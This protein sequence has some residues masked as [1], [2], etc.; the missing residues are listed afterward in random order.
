MRARV[1]GGW[2]SPFYPEE[3]NFNYTEANAWQYNFYVP[4]DVYGLM[5]LHG[6]KKEFSLLLDSLFTVSSETSGREQADISG[7]IGQYAHGNEPS[8]HMAY[9][10]CYAEQPE[11]TQVLVRR[12]LEELYTDQPDGLSGNEDCGQMSAWYVFS[13]LGFYPVNPAS[14]TYVIGSPLVDE[15]L[16]DLESGQSLKIIVHN[17]SDENVYVKKMQWNKKE[18]DLPYITF[19]MIREGGL[20]EFEMSDKPGSFNY[21]RSIPE[22]TLEDRSFVASPFVVNASRTFT[23]NMEIELDHIDDEV[24]IEYSLNDAPFEE[25]N[26]SIKIEDDA[27]L[28]FVAKKD[29]RSSKAVRS[30]F[31]KMKSERSIS[32]SEDYASQYSAGGNNALIDQLRGTNDF[33]TG[34]WQG[35]QGVDLTATVDLGYTQSISSVELGCLQDWNSWIFMPEGMVVY[36]SNDGRNYQSIG[37]VTNTVD[38][39]EE[40]CIIQD[41]KVDVNRSARYVKVEVESKKQNPDW[42]RAPGDRCWIFLDEIVINSSK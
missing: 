17:N 11:K 22:A 31:K 16:I 23:G 41:L 32:L 9:L 26:S 33:R 39:K 40:G 14:N 27:E 21:D 18:Y 24:I 10:Y 1:N 6:G 35:Y 34:D 42:H 5:E 38:E 13:A 2:F 37:T 4:H 29:G 12:I 20:L 36:V 25:Y 19:D 8:H 15:A 7:L 28:N 30:I 3:V